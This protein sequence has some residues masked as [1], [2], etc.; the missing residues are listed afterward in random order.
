MRLK[1]S[2]KAKDE[3]PIFLN[4]Y[5]RHQIQG[6]LYSMFSENLAEF[7]H[8]TGYRT[9]SGQIFKLFTF[10]DIVEAPAKIN[11][12][13]IIFNEGLSFIFSSNQEDIS[14]DLI[15]NFFQEKAI[16][17]GNNPVKLIT[18][19]QKIEP[20]FETTKIKIK[21]LAPLVIKTARINGGKSYYLKPQDTEFIPLLEQN[22]LKKAEMLTI[23]NNKVFTEKAFEFKL[24]Q[25]V[26]KKRI[27]YIKNI[28][29]VGWMDNFEL[30]GDKVLLKLAYQLGLGI[31]NS[32]GF[33]LFEL[34]NSGLKEEK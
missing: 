11:D 15:L 28:V 12:N 22:L 32:A 14:N 4:K 18:V 16:R 29:V 33:G 23:G 8:T 27:E 21:M 17:L 1:L 2:F 7:L 26:S 3:S 9:K 13:Q 5:Y 19:E 30:R 20:A 6:L 25:T 24:L 34:A 31:N 10:S